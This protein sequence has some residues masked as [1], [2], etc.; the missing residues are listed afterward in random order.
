VVVENDGNVVIYAGSTSVSA[1]NTVQAATGQAA[2]WD[3]TGGSAPA[4][5]P[6]A[7]SATAAVAS[8]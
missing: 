8:G 7:H 4:E 2:V 5:P 3:P 6:L 1:S